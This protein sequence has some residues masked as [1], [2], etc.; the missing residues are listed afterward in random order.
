MRTNTNNT[1]TFPRTV[2][3]VL[4][5]KN[6]I[7]LKADPEGVWNEDNADELALK[8]A[9]L[10]KKHKATPINIYTPEPSAKDNQYRLMFKRAWGGKPYLAYMPEATKPKTLVKKLA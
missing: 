7:A 1:N 3:I 9:E 4:D 2:S 8:C 6:R 5:T 10:A